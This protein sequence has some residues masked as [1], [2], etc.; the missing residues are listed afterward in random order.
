MA[1]VEQKHPSVSKADA[2]TA[3][4]NKPNISLINESIIIII[5]C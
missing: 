3:P 5:L 1:N 4:V 2:S